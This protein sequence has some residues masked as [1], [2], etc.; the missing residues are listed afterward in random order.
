MFSLALLRQSSCTSKKYAGFECT[1]VSLGCTTGTSSDA[2]L[3]FKVCLEMSSSCVGGTLF[4]SDPRA[5]FTSAIVVDF[6]FGN[7]D[8]H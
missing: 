5:K 6:R 4:L 3:E 8:G 7:P 1:K 2:P